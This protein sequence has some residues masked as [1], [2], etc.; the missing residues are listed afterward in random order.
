MVLPIVIYVLSDGATVGS[1]F[2]TLWMILASASDNILKPILL[3]RGVDV[4]MLVIF[5]GSIGGFVSSGFVGLFIGP[6][7]LSVGYEL[8]LAW[9]EQRTTATPARDVA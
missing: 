4:P 9:V 8:L 3:A 1:V 7:V 6:V 5:I 2:F